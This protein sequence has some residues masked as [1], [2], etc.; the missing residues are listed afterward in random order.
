MLVFGTA[1]VILLWLYLCFVALLWGAII[2]ADD[3]R[4]ADALRTRTSA[5][6]LPPGP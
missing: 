3:Q 2:E 6:D 1:V 4:R 5:G